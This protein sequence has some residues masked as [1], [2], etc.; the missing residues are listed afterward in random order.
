MGPS[1]PKGELGELSRSFDEMATS[2]AA[3]KEER[4]RAEE[5]LRRSEEEH[6]SIL[7]NSPLGIFRSTP[8]G[9]ILMANPALVK[10]LG[11]ESE[12]ELITMNLDKDIYVN[13]EDRQRVLREYTTRDTI[14]GA[15]LVWKRKDGRPINVRAIGRLMQNLDGS[16]AYFEVFA[17]D[18]T[19]QYL[20]ER[21]LKTAQRMEAV[22]TLAGGIAHDFNNALTGIVGFGEL[23]RMRVEGDPQPL[24]DLDE[25]MRCAERAATLTRSSL[26]TP[27]GRSWSLSI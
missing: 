18:M 23:L 8:D 27:A 9:K 14:I 25:I 6:R 26:R 10:M 4:N 2:L 21:Q 3:R 20:L 15:E 12:S 5:A 11:Y 13:P 24:H 7:S 16:P 1:Y 17:E 22:G 19:K